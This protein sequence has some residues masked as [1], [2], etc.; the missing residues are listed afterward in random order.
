M[1]KSTLFLQTRL[2]KSIWPP[3]RRLII[4]GMPPKYVFSWCRDR[5]NSKIV[6]A[7][8]CILGWCRDHSGYASSALSLSSVCHPDDF[9]HADDLGT[10]NTPTWPGASTCVSRS[11]GNQSP[12]NSDGIAV[13]ESSHVSHGLGRF[14]EYSSSIRSEAALI[15]RTYVSLAMDYVDFLTSKIPSVP[16]ISTK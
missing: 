11:L 13:P 14:S 7:K 12:K 15:V 3:S 1:G 8:V 10:R 16:S 4:G 9:A 5:F 6:P 2:Q